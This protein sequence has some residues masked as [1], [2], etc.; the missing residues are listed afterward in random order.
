MRA[1]VSF[2]G[3]QR[4]LFHDDRQRRRREGAID[5]S[6]YSAASHTS[7]AEDLL[8]S[9]TAMTAWNSLSGAPALLS[10]TCQ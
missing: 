5:L 9:G 10:P 7:Q 6:R 8:E 1:F 4:R 3:E 2:P